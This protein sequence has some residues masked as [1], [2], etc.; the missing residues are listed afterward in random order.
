MG[1]AYTTVHTSSDPSA[2][3]IQLRSYHD[4]IRWLFPGASILFA[5]VSHGEFKGGDLVKK[6]GMLGK[7]INSKQRRYEFFTYS[8]ITSVATV[9]SSTGATPNVL[10]V[11]TVEGFI[12]ERTVINDRTLEVGVIS[13]VSGLTVTVTAISAAFSGS[14]GDKVFVMAPAY[15]EAST[16]PYTVRKTEDNNY[17]VHQ[18]LRYPWWVSKSAMKSD[19]IGIKTNMLDEHGKRTMVM[20][21]MLAERSFLFGQRATTSTTDLTADATLANSIGTMHGFW[22]F[23]QNTFDGAN[24]MTYDRFYRDL[25]IA[26]GDYVNPAEKVIMLCGR[27]IF[28]DMQGWIHNIHQ[29]VKDGDL[30]KF[31][32]RSFKFMTAGPEIEVVQ[33]DLFN[34]GKF[35][36]RALL[37]CP[38]VLQYVHRTDRDLKVNKNIQSNDA[39]YIEHEIIGELTCA[40]LAGGYCSTKITDW[41]AL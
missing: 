22:N 40:D 33:H 18:I 14:A 24:A 15:P 26:M 28:G 17:N 16:S 13:A 3:G 32:V 11:D 38:D 19:N 29:Q 8:P 20:G 37:L 2:T 12:L 34:Q 5:F 25:P 35:A 23:A 10:T 30:S 39:D 36:N 7:K 21:N 31:G 6:Q 27:Y 9:S 1:T 41:F 4:K